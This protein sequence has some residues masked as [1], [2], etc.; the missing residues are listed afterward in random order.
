MAEKIVEKCTTSYHKETD[1]FIKLMRAVV[2]LLEAELKKQ[3]I[4]ARVSGRVKTRD[5][6]RTK[7]EKWVENPKKLSK[8]KKENGVF[9]TVGDLAAVRVMTYVESDRKK[10]VKI[11]KE[12]FT[13]REGQKNFEEEEKENDKRIDKDKNNFYRATHMQIC[14]RE[15]DL[16]GD[17]NNLHGDHCELQITSMLAHVWNEIEHDIGYKD[18]SSKLSEDEKLALSSLGYL[19]QSGDSI[20]ANLISANIRRKKKS[21]IDSQAFKTP[22]Q[23]SE[24][25]S[26]RFGKR[27]NN[28]E[29]DYKENTNH[30]LRALKD[31]N[32]DHPNDFAQKITL[33]GL[34]EARRERIRFN[35][36]LLKNDG[37]KHLL[38]NC[39]CDIFLLVLFKK[40]G[41]KLADSSLNGKRRE[42]ALARQYR[43]F[44]KK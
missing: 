22:K 32:L 14:L 8:L 39:S 10:V 28:E 33:K 12:I 25:L 2:E 17:N 19:T 3:G 7:L 35:N 11:A 43:A 41:L 21:E 31:I 38:S 18:D 4:L 20:I 36:Y 26:D 37:K 40:Y 13:H 9:T 6:L 23:L 1:R 30:L 44:C 5:S 42:V 16:S 15:K 29:I 24:F 27:I 34:D